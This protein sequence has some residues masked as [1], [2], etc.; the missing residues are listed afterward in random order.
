MDGVFELQD[1]YT[2]HRDVFDDDIRFMYEVLKGQSRAP[3]MDIDVELHKM[4]KDFKTWRKQF[5][6][7][8]SVDCLV[9]L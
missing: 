1:S 2:K 3:E 4:M 7:Q 5:E 6:V 8:R 9:P